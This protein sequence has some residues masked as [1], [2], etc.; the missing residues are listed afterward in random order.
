MKR[1]LIILGSIALLIFIYTQISLSIYVRLQA[2]SI[3]NWLNGNE[4]NKPAVGPQAYEHLKWIKEKGSVECQ[5]EVVEPNR[6]F[7]EDDVKTILI[8]GH[9]VEQIRLNYTFSSGIRNFMKPHYFHH[10]TDFPHEHSE[11]RINYKD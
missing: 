9:G 7:F 1:I 8:T 3:C 4:E 2:K 6:D 10:Q 5:C 11:F